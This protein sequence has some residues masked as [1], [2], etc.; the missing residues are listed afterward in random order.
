MKSLGDRMKEYERT[1][2]LSL[3]GR[4]PVVIRLDGKGFSN[5]TK[6]NKFEKPYDTTLCQAMYDS[7]KFTCSRIEGC[8]IG[9]TQSDE[10]TI[11]IRND[12]SH[13]SEPWFG[14]RVQ[15]MSSVV[16]SIFTARF[17]QIGVEHNWSLAFFDAR[18]FAVPTVDEAINC[19]IWRQ[20]EAVKN[21][22]YGA[23]Y[24]ELSNVTGRKKAQKMMHG[25]NQNEQQELLFSE[26]GKNWNDYPTYYKRGVAVH[27]V[28]Y[29]F[30]EDD[31]TYYRSSWEPNLETPR[32]TAD[33]EFLKS[34]LEGENV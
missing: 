29:E 31:N 22:I 3:M 8:M 27:K 32:F 34:I 12:Q 5:W 9:Y 11:V 6:S 30:K 1:A 26:A 7:L 24:Y 28:K 25:K 2:D 15:K 4:V 33:K 19:L 21:S 17:N 13:E 20:N 18:V 23:C 10:A 16:S 14:N